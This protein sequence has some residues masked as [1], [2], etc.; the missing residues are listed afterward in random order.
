MSSPAIPRP[1]WI[2][3]SRREPLMVG[4]VLQHRPV[5]ASY[6]DEVGNDIRYRTA[7]GLI[8]VEWAGFFF[9]AKID[10]MVNPCYE[11]FPGLR[12]EPK[13]SLMGQ[14]IAGPSACVMLMP[15]YVG[16]GQYRYVQL[17]TGDFDASHVGFVRTYNG[18]FQI[19]PLCVI[20]AERL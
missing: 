3:L 8:G 2:D 5:D 12:A 17:C 6:L 11:C 19:C 18:T 15:E 4:E 9:P 20:A 7:C 14:W 16:H 13:F 10:K 1:L